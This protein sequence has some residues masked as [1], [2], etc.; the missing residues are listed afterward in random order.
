M[1]PEPD[2]PARVHTPPAPVA[3]STTP[4]AWKPVIA[5]VA[6]ALLASVAP[7]VLPAWDAH[8][9]GGSIRWQVAAVA[10]ALAGASW[11]RRRLPARAARAGV[12]VLRLAATA[13]LLLALVWLAGVGLL[14]LVWPR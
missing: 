7:F 8:L 4:R 5:G 6:L 10:L 1:T 13:A 14:W 3:T 12:R 2:P 9:P 11:G